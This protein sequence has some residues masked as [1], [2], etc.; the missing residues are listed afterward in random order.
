[1]VGWVV[2]VLTGFIISLATGGGKP[3][4]TALNQASNAITPIEV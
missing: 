1:M 2:V 3:I 4:M